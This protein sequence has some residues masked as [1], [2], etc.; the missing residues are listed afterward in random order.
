MGTGFLAKEAPHDTIVGGGW[1]PVRPN[2][3]VLVEERE[4]PLS[5]KQKT[6]ATYRTRGHPWGMP[7]DTRQQPGV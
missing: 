7:F 4:A 1:E 5:P 3:F 2:F 6:V